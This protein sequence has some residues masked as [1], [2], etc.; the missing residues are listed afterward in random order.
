MCEILHDDM[1]QWLQKLLFLLEDIW[2]GR[3]TCTFYPPYLKLPPLN[4]MASKQAITTTLQRNTDTTN[5]SSNLSCHAVPHVNRIRAC[6]HSPMHRDSVRTHGLSCHLCTI[7]ANATCMS[8]T[9][10]NGPITDAVAV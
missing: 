5:V 8:R 1:L 10:I 2:A 4:E 6:C 3:N 9:P 7:R